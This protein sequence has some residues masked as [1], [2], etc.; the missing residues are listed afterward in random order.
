MVINLYYRMDKKTI[1]GQG[2]RKRRRGRRKR[3][4]DRYKTSFTSVDVF[5]CMLDRWIDEAILLGAKDSLRFIAKQLWFNYLKALGIAFQEGKSESSVPV[6]PGFRDIQ[7]AVTGRK[8]LLAP[9]TISRMKKTRTKRD[10]K[11]INLDSEDDESEEV[12]RKRRKDRRRFLNS[13]NNR[14]DSSSG[15]DGFQSWPTSEDF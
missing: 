10:K 9:E 7:V 3:G 5:G 8:R 12:K 1:H 11:P 6:V 14:G 2:R 4:D 15:T 13:L